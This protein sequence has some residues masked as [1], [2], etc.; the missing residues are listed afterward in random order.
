MGKEYSAKKN[1][2]RSIYVIYRKIRFLKR[3]GTLF[4]KKPLEKPALIKKSPQNTFQGK[5]YRLYRTLRFLIHTGKLFRKKPHEKP[6]LITKSPQNTF[7]GKIYYIYRLL[8]FQIHTGKLFR[9]S[10]KVKKGHTRPDLKIVF[11]KFRYL[12]NRR[13]LWSALYE[14][15]KMFIR[16]KFAFLGSREYL[17]ILINST[18]L[19]LLAYL[20]VYLITN[21]SV[22]IAAISFNIDSVL[23]YYDIDFLIRGSEWVPDA[24]KVVYTTGPFVSL[25]LAILAIIIYVNIAEETWIFRLFILWIFCHSFI[26]FFGEFLMGNLMGKGFGYVIMYLFFQDTPK[27]VLTLLDFVI[28]LFTGLGLTRLFLFSG[29]IYLN[30][31][32]KSNRMPFVLSQLF[33]PFL[34]GTGII[35][36]IKLPKISSLEIGVDFSMVILLLPVIFRARVSQDLFFEE[37]RKR[38]KLFWI[39]LVA[40]VILSVLFRIIFGIG[41]RI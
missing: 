18:A 2:S 5:I 7:R 21:V 14:K 22:I 34:I 27:M 25:I 24:V 40:A 38:I 17:L 1:L 29:N 32:D 36:L 26:H 30:K 41:I 13:K 12:F 31:L 8:R 4:R 33:L 16:I 35:L 19:F 15:I 6:I 10:N 3:R 9:G 23:Y 37:E 28:I 39:L 20:F 11:R